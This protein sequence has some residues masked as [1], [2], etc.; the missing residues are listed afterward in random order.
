MAPEQANGEEVD[1]RCDLFGLGAVLYRACTGELPFGGKDTLSVLKALAT[2]TPDPPHR[3]DPSLP[4]ALSD[5]VMRLLAK[6]RADRPQSARE[7]VEALAAIERGDAA[8]PEPELLEEIPPEPAP[9]IEEVVPVPTPIIK[10]VQEQGPAASGVKRKG[11]KKTPPPRRKKRPEPARDLGRRILVASLV[12][13]AVSLVV[14]LL[15]I[16]RYATRG[17]QAMG[18]EPARTPVVAANAAGSCCSRCS[19][20]SRC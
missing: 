11:P 7:V 4:R 10:K 2:T 18:N 16:I 6:D 19:R 5:L 20:P 8:E 12:L 1:G 17:R 9:E 15:G 14:L 13:L 3:I